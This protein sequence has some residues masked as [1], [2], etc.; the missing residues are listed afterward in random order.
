MTDLTEQWKKGKLTGEYWCEIIESPYPER[1][2][3]PTHESDIIVKVL[4]PALSYKECQELIESE[5]KSH[6]QADSYYNKILEL[7][8]LLKECS[9]RIDW[10]TR[11]LYKP[12]DEKKQKLFDEISKVLGEE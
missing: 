8:E 9:Y 6:L 12:S 4:A 5:A 2:Y 3:L 1:V 7:K 11:T 10:R